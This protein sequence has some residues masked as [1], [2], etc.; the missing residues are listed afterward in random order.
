MTAIMG[1]NDRQQLAD[2]SQL[3]QRKRRSALM[4]RGVT[5]DPDT[6]YL[7]GRLSRFIQILLLNRM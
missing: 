1:V 4:A 6:V 7:N 2:L 5:V 3:I